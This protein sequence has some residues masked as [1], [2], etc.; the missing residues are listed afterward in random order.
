MEIK[1]LYGCIG[2]S[3]IISLFLCFYIVQCKPICERAHTDEIDRDRDAIGSE[4]GA[5]E[6]AA[7]CLKLEY[8]YES[9]ETPYY[10]VE[11]YYNDLSYEWIVTFTPKESEEERVKMVAIRRD[12]DAITILAQ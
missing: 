10:D 2:I 11:V 6:I 7:A 4:E 1:I 9:H 12:Y 3:I 8:D 5:T